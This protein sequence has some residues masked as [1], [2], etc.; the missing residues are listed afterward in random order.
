MSLSKLTK[1]WAVKKLPKRPKNANK[2]TF[3]KVLVI[4]GSENYPGA[5]YLT[6]AAAY[7]V[8]TGLVTLA[9][10]REVK[11]IVSRKLPEVTFLSYPESLK[12]LQEYDVLILGPG[13]GQK[14][15]IKKFLKKKLPTL[16]IDGDGL[17]ILSKINNWWEKIAGDAVLTPHPGEMSRL[18]GQSVQQIQSNREKIAKQFAKKWRKIIVLKGANTLIVSPAGEVIK[19]PFANPLLATAGTGDVLAGIIAGLLAQGPEIFDA[20]CLGVYIHGLAAEF[21][22]E[23]LGDSGLLASDLLEILPKVIKKIKRVLTTDD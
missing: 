22:K 5:A 9:T 2:G 13:L 15:N 19:A 17:N 14:F 3:G 6:C 12:K 10:S 20:A 4:G 23:K 8:G 18:T 7:R 21:L 16:V 11:I 1:E